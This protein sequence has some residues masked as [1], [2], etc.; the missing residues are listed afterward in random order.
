[1]K[2]FGLK[3]PAKVKFPGAHFCD[4]KDELLIVG[5]IIK[6][7]RPKIIQIYFSGDDSTEKAFHINLDI[8]KSLIQRMVV[9]DS[10]EKDKLEDKT[11]IEFDQ[12]FELR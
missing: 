9:M 2:K 8:S 4:G 7:R 5:K 12:P 1:M 10:I 3:T 6:T 11:Y